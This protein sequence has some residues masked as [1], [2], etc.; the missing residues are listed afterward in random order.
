MR[1]QIQD[2]YR[3]LVGRSGLYSPKRRWNPGS[4][5]CQSR[6]HARGSV[7]GALAEILQALGGFLVTNADRQSL[8]DA[9]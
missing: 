5:D 6:K 1:T 9:E 4:P 2:D 7:D 8:V 3:G